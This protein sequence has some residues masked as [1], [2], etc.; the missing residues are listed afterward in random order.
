MRVTVCEL[1]HESEALAAA[2]AEALSEVWRHRLPEL[3]A[4]H[5]VGARSRHHRR[6]ALQPSVPLVRYESMYEQSLNPTTTGSRLRPS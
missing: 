3:R 5:V 2:W 6:P 1:P 4:T